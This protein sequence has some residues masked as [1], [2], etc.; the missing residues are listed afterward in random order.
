TAVR[1]WCK[2]SNQHSFRCSLE[3]AVLLGSSRLDQ[4]VA[5]A[6][7]LYARHE[8]RLVNS[9]PLSVRSACGCALSS[10]RELP[11]EPRCNAGQGVIAFHYKIRPIQQ[12]SIKVHGKS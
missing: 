4:D 1:G 2:I 5:D 10:L 7:C 9:G 11:A 8:A 3:V 6:M 12:R